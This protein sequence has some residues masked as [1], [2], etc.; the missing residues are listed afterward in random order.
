MREDKVRVVPEQVVEQYRVHYTEYHC[1]KCGRLISKEDHGDGY[2]H[3]LA[4]A[5]DSDECVNFFRQRDYCPACL[6]PI[7]AALNALIAADPDA[8]RDRDYD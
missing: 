3:E 4:V 2:A 5:L 7:W 1:D 8:E 6:D